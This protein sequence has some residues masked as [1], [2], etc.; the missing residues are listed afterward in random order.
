MDLDEAKSKTFTVYPYTYEDRFK[1]DLE[2]VVEEIKQSRIASNNYV[3][4]ELTEEI[5]SYDE[6]NTHEQEG[7]VLR[8]VKINK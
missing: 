8:R 5:N 6:T 4:N 3:E 2:A 1:D 7:P